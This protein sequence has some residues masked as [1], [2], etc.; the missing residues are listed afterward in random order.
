MYWICL[1]CALAV[2]VFCAVITSLTNS[3][4]VGDFCGKVVCVVVPL[5]ML[6]LPIYFVYFAVTQFKKANEIPEGTPLIESVDSS[7]NHEVYE[8]Q[9]H[10]YLMLKGVFG[11]IHH[12]ECE[13][14]D[15]LE[16]LK[17]Y[18]EGKQDK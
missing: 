8:F 6:S 1:T 5:A 14:R 17:Q 15:M 3:T 10:K 4:R 7:H 2:V 9:G 12:P 18:E 11:A 13:K 16:V